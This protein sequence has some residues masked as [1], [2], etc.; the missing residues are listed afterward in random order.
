M[1]CGESGVIPCGIA[2]EIPGGHEAQVR[3]RSGLATNHGISMPNAPGTV[4]GDYRGEIKVPLINHGDAPFVVE[5]QAVITRDNVTVEVD[6]VLYFHPV[7]ATD[8]IVKVRNYGK[9]TSQIALTTLRSVLGQFEL[10]ELL[11]H[12][13]RI[14]ERLAEIIDEHTE[15]WG[16]QAGIVGDVGTSMR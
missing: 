16:V 4:D 7:N 15:P 1:K 6:A 3:P 13:D 8:T 10:D 5:P 9:A 11:S 14:N 12:R 2:V